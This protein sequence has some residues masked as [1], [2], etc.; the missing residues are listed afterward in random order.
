MKM[1]ETI[2]NR[3]NIILNNITRSITYNSILQ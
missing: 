2:K 3:D 1:L